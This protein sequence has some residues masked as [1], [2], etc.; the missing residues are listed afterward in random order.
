MGPVVFEGVHER[1]GHFGAHEQPE[2]IVGDL[3]LMFGKKGGAY[4]VVKGKD[5]FVSGPKL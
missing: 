5:G 4:G 3:R 2:A 1:G